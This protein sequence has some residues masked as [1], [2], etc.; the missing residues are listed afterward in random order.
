MI[1]S[2]LFISATKIHCILENIRTN[3]LVSK[4]NTRSGPSVMELPE[5]DS[6]PKVIIFTLIVIL[7]VLAGI[8]ESAHGDDPTRADQRQNV[9]FIAVDDLRP[10]SAAIVTRR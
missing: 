4:V 5:F 2:A 7:N 8:S 3:Q 10:T 6:L 1:R 9:L